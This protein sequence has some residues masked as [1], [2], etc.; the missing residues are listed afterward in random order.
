MV[1]LER[2]R[3]KFGLSVK[4]DNGRT[5][6][7]DL[8]Q[9]GCCRLLFPRLE[10]AGLE[11]VLVN[12]S[13]GIAAGDHILGELTC[14]VGTDLMVT[15]QAAERI[16]RARKDDPAARIDVTCHIAA[17]A[18]LEWLPHETIFFDQS[19]LVRHMSVNMQ[20]T[21]SFLYLESRVFGRGGS[22]EVLTS[23][24]LRDRL[25]VSRAGALVFEDMLRLESADASA[26]LAHPAVAG[27]QGAVTTLVLISQDAQALL[28]PV[29]NTLVD[30]NM[31]GFAASAWNGMLVVRGVA[32][33]AWPLKMAMQHILPVLRTTRPM[34]ATWRL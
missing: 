23:L 26:L 21:S 16:Y 8:V 13:G 17:D 29:R 24:E 32:A 20:A 2:A 33:S 19:R 12:I 34:P 9:G 14:G 3:G 15:S 27:G 30:N 10:H 11:A 5:R 7:V 4:E 31:V 6:P 25:S 28:Q 1:A 22:D 18:R